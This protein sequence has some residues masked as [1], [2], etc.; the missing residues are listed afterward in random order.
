MIIHW[1]Q[2]TY[3]ILM[4]LSLGATLVLNGKPRENYSFGI[5]LLSVGITVSLLY[6]GGF[7]TGGL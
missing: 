6:M 4:S 5:S 7:F 2:I 1:P 3:I